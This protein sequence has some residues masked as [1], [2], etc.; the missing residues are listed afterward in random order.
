LGQSY[1]IEMKKMHF[2]TFFLFIS[3]IFANFAV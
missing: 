2:F 1:E 3:Y